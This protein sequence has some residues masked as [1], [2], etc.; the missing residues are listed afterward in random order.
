[1]E[2]AVTA[3]YPIAAHFADAAREAELDDELVRSAAGGSAGAQDELSRRYRG[4]IYTFALTVLR[5]PDDAED[6]TQDV[7]VRAFRGLG[8]YRG[9]GQFRAWLFKIAAN[10]SRDQLRRRTRDSRSGVDEELEA[11]PDRSGETDA[12]IVLRTTVR[13]AIGRLPVVYRAPVVLYYLEQLSTAE[14]GAIL[15]RSQALVKVQLWRAR[16]LLARELDG[17]LD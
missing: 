6:L 8:S 2:Q 15:G 3:L 12:G 1:M 17:F 10:L 13:E 7:F 5:R 4:R 11:M 16:A 14:V 9:R